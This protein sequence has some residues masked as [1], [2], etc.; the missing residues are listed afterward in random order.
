MEALQTLGNIQDVCLTPKY[1]HLDLPPENEL[2]NLSF[3]ELLSLSRKLRDAEYKELDD[4]TERLEEEI[5]PAAQ[6]EHN[7]IVMY[8][9]FMIDMDDLFGC[10]YQE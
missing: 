6:K 1:Y 3:K 4:E 10:T 7:R 5:I 2:V 9:D 8:N